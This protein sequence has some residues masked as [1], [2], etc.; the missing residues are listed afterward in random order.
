MALSTFYEYE[1]RR[2]LVGDGIYGL[3][4]SFDSRW[5]A[6]TSTHGEIQI[7]EVDDSY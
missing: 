4:W 3:A 5:L 2:F 1:S 7:L 6:L